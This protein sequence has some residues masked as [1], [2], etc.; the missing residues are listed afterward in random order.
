MLNMK[1]PAILCFCVCALFI[2]GCGEKKKESE[3]EP[4]SHTQAIKNVIQ[5][6]NKLALTLKQDIMT[7][8]PRTNEEIDR[9]SA[10]ISD[11]V[12][13]A[14]SIK[15]SSCPPDYAEAFIRYIASWSKLARIMDNHPHIR[16]GEE[17]VLEGFL[18]GLAGDPTGGAFEMQS[19]YK[20][21][22]LRLNAAQLQLE[23]KWDELS[24][25]AARHGIY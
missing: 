14:R 20:N 21:W 7:S 18:R 8:P 5:S 19:E 13:S 12:D 11:F 23:T 1:I 2:A 4:V 10:L 3:P 9:C 6:H 15:L 25:V 17:A 16:S 22:V 24:A